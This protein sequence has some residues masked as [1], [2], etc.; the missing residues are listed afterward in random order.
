MLP[1]LA[2]TVL[3]L[4]I[5]PI[6][7]ASGDDYLAR[8]S[9][10]HQN[11]RATPAPGGEVEPRTP[12]SSRPVTYARLEGRDVEGFLALPANAS[13]R[14]GLL[15]I[16]QWWGLND[17]MRA[18]TE[19]FAGE[20]YAAL[21]VDLYEGEVATD[22]ENA[23]RLARR[24]AQSQDRAVDNLRQATAWLRDELGVEKVGVVG[25]CF[26]GGWSLQAGLSQGDGL[27]AVVM[28]YGRVV[29]EPDQLASLTAPLLGHF[30]GIDTGIPVES[31]REFAAALSRRQHDATV[32]V[33]EGAGHAFASP[34]SGRYNKEAAELSWGRTIEFLSQH[35]R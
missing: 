18:L 27:D 29:T 30:G 16:H 12:T 14:A 22:V 19:R 34:T 9:R 21:A 20:G 35:L 13:P 3:C 33:Y 5:G 17:E 15:L 2:T 11:D 8:M 7:A 10:E 1:R 24:T 31:A 23:G 28:Y 4:L 6:A 25:W 26:G 32:Y